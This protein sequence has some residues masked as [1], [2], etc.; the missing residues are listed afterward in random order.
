MSGPRLRRCPTC[1]LC[2]PTCAFPLAPTP[3][4]VP[5]HGTLRRTCLDCGFERAARLFAIVRRRPPA[6]RSPELVA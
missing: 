5:Q 4:P 1:G 2:A 3:L 6:D